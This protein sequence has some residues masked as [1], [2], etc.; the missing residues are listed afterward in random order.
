MSA[1]QQSIL[2]APDNAQ[3]RTSIMRAKKNMTAIFI[4]EKK[5]SLTTEE[6]IA[7]NFDILNKYI[8]SLD[9]KIRKIVEHNEAEVLLAYRNHFGRI[10]E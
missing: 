3:S 4:T 7:E 9:P 6:I 8:D 5:E 2:S 1:T 10:R